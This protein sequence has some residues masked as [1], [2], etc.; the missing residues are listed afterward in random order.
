M[1]HQQAS[2]IPDLDWLQ[3]QTCQA[4]A[5][6]TAPDARCV[7]AAD[8]GRAPASLIYAAAAA[9]R[10]AVLASLCA[11]FPAAIPADL[12]ARTIAGGAPGAIAA[13]I[14]WLHAYGYPMGPLSIFREWMTPALL[15]YLVAAD[16]VEVSDWDAGYILAH[17]STEFVIAAYAPG[18]PLTSLFPAGPSDWAKETFHSNQTRDTLAIIRH[19][20]ALGWDMEAVPYYVVK[21][22][23]LDI[24][25]WLG[26]EGILDRLDLDDVSRLCRVAHDRR[27]PDA[28][29][30]LEDY[31]TSRAEAEAAS[32][33]Q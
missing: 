20:Y 23:Y 27:S 15:N 14:Q 6:S 10:T 22:D 8:C 24:L 9:G 28:S 18:A 2:T 31:Y 3:A 30:W 33:A 5:G 21:Y 12:V 1:S 26:S 4:C 7:L 19:C 13:T 29:A 17:R 11:D 32:G 25:A 16:L